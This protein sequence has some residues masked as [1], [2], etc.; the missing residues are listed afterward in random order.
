[1]LDR[2]VR[3]FQVGGGSFGALRSL[4]AFP[5]NL[6]RQVTS[7]VGREDEVAAV[8]SALAESPLVTMT[9][10]GGV[11]KTRLALQAAAEALPSYGVGAWL[12]ELGPVRDGTQVPEAVTAVFSL[13]VGPG[14]TPTDVLVEFL[15]NKQL[16]VVVDNCEHVIGAAAALVSAVMA[17]CN[18]AVVLA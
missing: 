15:R 3:V 11:G 9:G 2:P 1:D 17:S 14:T 18:G 6:P 13:S 8:V 5:G 10:V 4:D 12:V 16:L 7:F